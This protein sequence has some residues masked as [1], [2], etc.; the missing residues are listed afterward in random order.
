MIA[1]NCGGCSAKHKWE[2]SSMISSWD[3]AMRRWMSSRWPGVH[4]S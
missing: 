2:A 4:S 1:A 3:P